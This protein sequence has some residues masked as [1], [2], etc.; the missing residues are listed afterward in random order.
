MLL[1][2]YITMAPGWDRPFISRELYPLVEGSD[3][4]CFLVEVELP[5][6]EKLDGVI[7]AVAIPVDS[8][9]IRLPSDPDS[10]KSEG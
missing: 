2:I 1:P 3:A 4:K 8:A 5:G 10:V 7:R 9:G 6:F